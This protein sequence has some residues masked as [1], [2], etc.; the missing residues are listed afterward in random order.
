MSISRI[1][2]EGCKDA[3]P[4]ERHLSEKDTGISLDAGNQA[5]IRELYPR[6]Q[7]CADQG[8]RSVEEGRES[9]DS[10]G[11]S[12]S[13][14]IGLPGLHPGQSEVS[15]AMHYHPRPVLEALR[16]SSSSKDE[17]EISE[18]PDIEGELVG[19][20]ANS[21][22]AITGEERP[23]AEPD[24]GT[25][26]QLLCPKDRD[27]KADDSRRSGVCQYGT[28]DAEGEGAD[29]RTGENLLLPS[30]H[31]RG[32][33]GVSGISCRTPR[34]G[35]LSRPGRSPDLHE[36]RRVEG[37]HGQRTRQAA[38]EV[39]REGGNRLRLSHA[40]KIGP[41]GDIQGRGRSADYPE[42]CRASERGHD[43]SLPRDS[44]DG[45]PSGNGAIF[46]VSETGREIRP[47]PQYPATNIGSNLPGATLSPGIT[48]GAIVE[49]YS[50]YADLLGSLQELGIEPV[51]NSDSDALN[52]KA[53]GSS[54]V[55][56]FAPLANSPD[57]DKGGYS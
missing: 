43:H 51:I 32:H 16:K 22:S 45:Y 21:L 15:G 14:C 5:V 29:G 6:E 4:G 47:L 20:R 18:R 46:G 24:I 41:Q 31:S 34:K 56:S 35:L 19:A 38:E 49:R 7:A 23:Q 17:P 10:E 36:G 27:S 26:V 40:A 11:D 37:L 44:I 39:Q 9:D 28:P 52:E 33:R 57:S 3:I 13:R 12:A 50:A 48:A 30:R 2:L 42:A 54:L 55:L 25:R 53:G 1:T 8:A